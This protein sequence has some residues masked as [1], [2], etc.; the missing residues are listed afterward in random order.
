MVHE[1]HVLKVIN[2]KVYRSV[3]LKITVGR[4]VT[5][6]IPIMYPSLLGKNLHALRKLALATFRVYLAKPLFSHLPTVGT[7]PS[8]NLASSPIS[9]F[10]LAVPS[11][12]NNNIL[13]HLYSHPRRYSQPPLE[14]LTSG[15][16]S[17]RKKV[18]TPHLK[19]NRN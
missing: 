13:Y 11:L 19:S 18:P 8:P 5:C 4:Y 1:T 14:K 10:K 9:Y 7:S 12:F 3:A 2:V 17:A 15:D 6:I 16:L